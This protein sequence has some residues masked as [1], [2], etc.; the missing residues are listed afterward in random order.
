MPR[1]GSRKAGDAR[2]HE[3]VEVRVDLPADVRERY[4]YFSRRFGQP[5]GQLYR[6]AI[7]N[8]ARTLERLAARDTE[9]GIR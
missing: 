3:P 1:G 4:G 9:E 7:I 8:N 6:E 2:P 5:V